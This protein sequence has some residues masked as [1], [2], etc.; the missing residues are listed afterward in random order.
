LPQ[1]VT[2][3]AQAPLM[4]D[5]HALPVTASDDGAGPAVEIWSGTPFDAFVI[6][7]FKPLE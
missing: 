3:I 1:F 7:V 6:D 4:E 5:R 2:N